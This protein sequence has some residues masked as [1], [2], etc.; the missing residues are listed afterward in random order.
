MLRIC[1]NAGHESTGAVFIIDSIISHC[2][3]LTMRLSKVSPY[4][5]CICSNAGND[6]GDILS[7]RN[8]TIASCEFLAPM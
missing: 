8:L 2:F 7:M 5:S 3:C 4:L 6:P 1:S